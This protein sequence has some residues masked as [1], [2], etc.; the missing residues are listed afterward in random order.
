MLPNQILVIAMVN[1][2]SSSSVRNGS[3]RLRPRW[4]LFVPF[5]FFL[6]LARAEVSIEIDLSSQKAWLVRDGVR[7]C[8]SAISS[9][10]R[11][12]ETA[13]GEY[14]VLG[15]TLDHRSSLYGRIVDSRGATLVPDVDFETPRPAGAKFVQ[16]P[17]RYFLRFDGA[18][19][20]HAGRLPGY[21]ASHGCVRLP[22]GKAAIFYEHAQIGTPVR[23]V[24]RAPGSTGR[25]GRPVRADA[26]IEGRLR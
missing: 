4:I 22:L 2:R 10:R 12:H 13:A 19:G 7:V 26:P 23:I 1:R 18:I 3:P 9:G 6:H 5:L 25:G 16:A 21:P 8:E 11:G 15:K 14:A 17:M 24:G 20:M